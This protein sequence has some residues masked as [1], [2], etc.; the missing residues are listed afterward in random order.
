MMFFVAQG[1]RVFAT[2]GA[3]TALDADRGGTTWTTMPTTSRHPAHLDLKEPS[4]SAIPPAA[5]GRALPGA[6]WREP[7]RK[8]VIIS[9]CRR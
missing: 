2:T 4:T 6:P 9:R 5:R 8:A 7:G 3:A 1:Y